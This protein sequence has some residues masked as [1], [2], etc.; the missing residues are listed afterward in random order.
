MRL[1]TFKFSLIHMLMKRDK[2]RYSIAGLLLCKL[3]IKYEFRNH[4]FCSQFVSKV[5]AESCRMK[6]PKHASLMHPSD[7]LYVSGVSPVYSGE[8]E[9]IR[10]L[11]PPRYYTRKVR[12]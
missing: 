3:G 9:D 12:A 1:N 10:T 2:L 11:P 5:L 8:L 6:L 7:L 4:F